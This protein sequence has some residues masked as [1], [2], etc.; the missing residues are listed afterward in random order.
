MTGRARTPVQGEVPNP[1]EPADAA[2]PSIRAARMPTSAAAS[3]GRA[4]ARSAA[5]GSR[6]TRSR[7]GGSERPTARGQRVSRPSRRSPRKRSAT[8]S[9][10]RTSHGSPPATITSAARGR[11][12]CS[13]SPCSC[14]R[15]RPRAP[16]EVARR[17]RERA[18][19]AEPVARLADRPDDVAAQRRARRA[20]SHATISSTPRR[21]PAASGR[22]SRR[23]RCRSS[24]SSPGFRYEHLAHQ[25]AGVADERAAGL[26]Q[27]LAMA[28]AARVDAFEQARASASRRPAAS[29]S[30]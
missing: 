29:S 17:D 30:A 15:R 21:A 1:L 8:V 14:R 25:H 7:K 6:A 23:R 12:C 19:A 18:V 5:R 9:R 22:S 16:R 20:R 10:S 3:S 2:A 26:E 13:C 11:G 28:V 4:A 24:S 27:E